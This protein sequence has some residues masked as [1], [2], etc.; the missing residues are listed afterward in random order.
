MVRSFHC[1]GCRDHSSFFVSASLSFS[2]GANRASGADSPEEALRLARIWWDA[3]VE[4]LQRALV[5]A[6]DDHA[7]V[8]SLVDDGRIVISSRSQPIGDWTLSSAGFRRLPEGVVLSV[9]EGKLLMVVDDNDS[10]ARAVRSCTSTGPSYCTSMLS[11]VS[12]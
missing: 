5:D 1:P 8:H 6:L 3:F 9:D 10:L 11:N 2:S 7:V 12:G 4:Q